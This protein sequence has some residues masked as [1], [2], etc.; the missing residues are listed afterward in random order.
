[1]N[2]DM[3]S[4]QGDFKKNK[5]K[6][7]VGAKKK[8]PFLHLGR[9]AEEIQ[10][11]QQQFE[12]L[13]ID[14]QHLKELT[15]RQ[16]QELVLSQQR[17][18]D[19]MAECASRGKEVDLAKLDRKEYLV[20]LLR[21]MADRKNDRLLFKLLE[22]DPKG[23]KSTYLRSVVLFFTNTIKLALVGKKGE[24]LT[25]DDH[26]Q[27]TFEIRESLPPFPCQAKVIRRGISL[28]GEIIIQPQVEIIREKEDTQNG[29]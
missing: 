11:V 2:D 3:H 7:K 21:D 28:E 10:Q 16:S 24:V 15:D 19:L 6:T 12:H 25:L 4:Q 9:L 26:N 5:D 20:S 1:M 13:V 17:I 22:L 14:N 18:D 29:I 27:H 23:I 8:Q